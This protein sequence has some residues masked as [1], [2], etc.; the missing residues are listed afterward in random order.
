MSYIFYPFY[1]FGLYNV[2][3]EIQKNNSQLSI[4]IY[5]DT[6]S[7]RN[8][9]LLLQLVIINCNN[10]KNI[11]FFASMLELIFWPEVKKL[12]YFHFKTWGKECI[13]F[14]QLYS[15]IFKIVN[16]IRQL[17]FQYQQRWSLIIDVKNW[18]STLYC[19]VYTVWSN[20]FIFIDHITNHTLIAYR[21]SHIICILYSIKYFSLARKLNKSFKIIIFLS[22][23]ILTSFDLEETTYIMTYKS[24]DL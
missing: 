8:S 9:C 2:H 10:C 16:D 20:K 24:I 19:P 21:T 5:N 6:K 23:F 15:R 4:I 13:G 17:L 14:P 3:I 1:C 11:R 7:I 22:V 12:R 18:C